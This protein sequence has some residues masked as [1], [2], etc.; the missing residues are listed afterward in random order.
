MLA[1][2]HPNGASDHNDASRRRGILG[3][4]WGVVRESRGKATVMWTHK[5]A[6]TITA[7]AECNKEWCFTKALEWMVYSPIIEK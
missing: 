7:S 6:S 1:I 4:G 3:P 2:A 5:V